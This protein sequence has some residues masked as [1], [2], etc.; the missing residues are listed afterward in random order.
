MKW[1]C[2]E[3]GLPQKLMDGFCERENPKLKWRALGVPPWVIPSAQVVPE[4]G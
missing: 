2:P 4:V 3:K 1:W